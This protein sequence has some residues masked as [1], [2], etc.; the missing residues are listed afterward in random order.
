MVALDKTR[1]IGRLL[2]FPDKS[3]PIWLCF[4]QGASDFDVSATFRKD[5]DQARAPILKPPSPWGE[6]RGEGAHGVRSSFRLCVSAPASPHPRFARP[7][8][9]G[10]VKSA[11][12]SGEFFARES[13]ASLS[14]GRGLG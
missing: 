13:E 3:P 10:E 8:P 5:S 7:L 12:R 4:E 9:K 2:S 11:S 6:G 1:L 14:S